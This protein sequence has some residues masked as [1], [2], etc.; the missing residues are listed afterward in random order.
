MQKPLLAALLCLAGTGCAWLGWSEGDEAVV[1]TPV[2]EALPVTVTQKPATGAEWNTE[3]QATRSIWGV[4]P[5]PPSY[6]YDLKPEMI[7]GSAVAVGPATLLVSCRIVGSR[8]QLVVTQ[9]NQYAVADL[10]AADPVSNICTLRVPEG[11]HLESVAGWR[12]I[13]ALQEGEPAFALVSQSA[14]DF[15]VSRGQIVAKYAEGGGGWLQTTLPL[16]VDALSA[17][18]FD[19]DGRLIGLGSAGLTADSMTMA[20]ALPAGLIP[21]LASRTLGALQ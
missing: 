13:A 6:A 19:S 12:G 9:Y 4:V 14:F 8:R 15:V 11:V 10:T 21:P 16:P 17:V 7:R 20:A 2:E 18:V 5:D 1:E 3:R